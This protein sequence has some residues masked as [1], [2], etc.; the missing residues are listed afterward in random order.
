MR[1]V[2]TGNHAKVPAMVAGYLPSSRFACESVR[3]VCTH[4]PIY[5]P[6]RPLK[7]GRRDRRGSYSKK[8]LLTL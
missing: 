5:L 4:A 7:G 8:R 2:L 6:D 3:Y 1:G